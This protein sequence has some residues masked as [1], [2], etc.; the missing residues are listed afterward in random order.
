MNPLNVLRGSALMTPAALLKRENNEVHLDMN[1]RIRVQLSDEGKPVGCTLDGRAGHLTIAD[2]QA[3]VS[4]G[5]AAE[6]D[7]IVA[8]ID[9]KMRSA[10]ELRR[11]SG[12]PIVLVDQL[13]RLAGLCGDDEIYRALLQQRRAVA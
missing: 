6:S 8:P 2:G 5:V 13:G 10:I 4:L 3:G 7:A 1:G 9:L 12:N 11:A